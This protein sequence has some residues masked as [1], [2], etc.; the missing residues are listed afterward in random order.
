MPSTPEAS[1]KAPLHYTFGNHM[2]WVDMEWLWGYGVLP[3][4]VND[5][6][7]YCEQGSVRG[8][9]NFDAAGYERLAVESPREFVR[10]REA[11]EHGTVEIVGASYGQ[12]YG[13]FHGG[14]SNVRQ[15]L[16]GVRTVQRLFGV[17]P[18]TFWEEEFD[19]FPQLPQM[20]AGAGY[21]HA[22]LFFQWTWHTPTI[23]EES[24]PAV[25][26]R[27]MD[28][29]TLLTATKNRYSVHQWPEDLKEILS[30]PELA[31]RGGGI[32]QWLELMPS[33]DWMCR[34]E[35]M[36]PLL[37]ELR[38][39]SRFELRSGTLR[40]YLDAVA[41]EAPERS[42]GLEDVFHGMSLGK[43]G[44]LFRRLSRDAESALL[45]AE[46]AA[47]VAGRFGRPYAHW[48]AYPTWELDEAW[49]ELLLAQHHDHDE[50][51][52]LCGFVG[53]R[54]YER[55]IEAAE[56]VEARSVGLLARRAGLS[57]AAPGS[58]LV[59]NPLGWSR[60]T[61]VERDGAVY[62]TPEIPAT[63]YA[64]VDEA[65]LRVTPI[66]EVAETEREIAL[67]SADTTASV[68]RA[69]G[70]LGSFGGSA[71]PQR[72]EEGFLQLERGG[73]VV[74]PAGVTAVR[75]GS[76]PE[77]AVSYEW[78]DGSL[79]CRIS[80]FTSGNGQPVAKVRLTSPKL[81]LLETKYAGALAL[82]LP[83]TGELR[84][85]HPFA[86]TPLLPSGT[87]TK[88]YP[89]GDWMTS[90][91]EYETLEN[92]V[93]ALSFYDVGLPRGSDSAESRRLQIVHDGSQAAF[94]QDGRLRIVLSM[95]DPW[96]EAY[97]VRSLD[98][99]LYLRVH[100][101]ETPVRLRRAADELLRPARVLAANGVPEPETGSTFVP[102]FQDSPFSIPDRFSLVSADAENVCITAVYREGDW[103]DLFP[104][105]AGT[106]MDQPLVVRIVEY[107]GVTG[108]V[109]LRVHGRVSRAVRTN[110]LGERAADDVQPKL[111]SA[112]DGSIVSLAVRAHEITT[113]YLDVHEMHP[114]PRNLDDHRD[115]WASSH[116]VP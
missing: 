8:N 108:A 93:T 21:T 9:V 33:P 99:T 14:E 78:P 16:W 54:S 97:F 51:E 80:L 41:N 31:E 79:E 71:K 1:R 35:L 57:T 2:H 6:L 52:G 87:H 110:L 55:A 63:G 83:V 27:G 76:A 86:I 60:P 102:E 84:H 65:S 38:E 113:L 94:L 13:L 5:M 49:R 26:W 101:A 88:K 30:E 91:Q 25:R 15:R 106:D 85:D 11:V 47:T 48:D 115:Q 82:S 45:S 74:E 116:R 10:L 37:K 75:N 34:S 61:T 77:I 66:P 112:Q 58:V 109:D 67:R 12:P 64:I 19:F 107:N 50:C 24:V 114:V 70:T 89:T 92:P 96:D 40:E 59:W 56:T 44:D 29:S 20:L 103:V 18:R 95:N 68:D 23:P 62:A 104:D 22:S 3:G 32:V 73:T 42:Y 39:D 46:S 100:T 7:A 53:K 4:S 81:P 111:T 28:G 72:L 105:Y 98:A 69:R 36:L 17:R 43:N 90:P